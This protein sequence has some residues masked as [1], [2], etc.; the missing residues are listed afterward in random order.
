MDGRCREKK[1][2][3]ISLDAKSPYPSSELPRVTIL[4]LVSHEVRVISAKDEAFQARDPERKSVIQITP[5][6]EPIGLN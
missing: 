5:N 4:G 2:G 1:R 6:L 3:D